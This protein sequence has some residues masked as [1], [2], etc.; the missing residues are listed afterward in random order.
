M[1]QESV[2]VLAS[3]VVSFRKKS[4]SEV[5]KMLFG[6]PHTPIRCL[7]GKKA[8]ITLKNDQKAMKSEAVATHTSITS[9]V[10][11]FQL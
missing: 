9:D 11:V 6:E 8:R 4:K 2:A 5:G 1:S 3:A 10:R 7:P